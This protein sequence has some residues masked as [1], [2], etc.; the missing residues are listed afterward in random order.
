MALELG[1]EQAIHER[2][3]ATGALT[4][5]VPAAR[6]F[7][8]TAV[9]SPAIP[10]VVWKRVAT[11]P[12]T[13]T[14]SGRNIDRTRMRCEIRTEQLTQ[15]KQIAQAVHDAFHRVAFSLTSGTCLTMQVAAYEETLSPQSW[16][17]AVTVYDLLHEGAG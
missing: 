16:W 6:V 13:R 3:A 15:A 8:G 9:G 10:Y 5:L 1:L 4:A 2:W 17:M 14:S 7:T 11:G 12:V